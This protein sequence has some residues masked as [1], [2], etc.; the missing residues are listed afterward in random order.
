MTGSQISLLCEFMTLQSHCNVGK[1]ISLIIISMISCQ[2]AVGCFNPL[3]LQS[4]ITYEM[5][6]VSHPF[7]H[8]LQFHTSHRPN[9]SCEI[10]ERRGGVVGAP[11]ITPTDN[12]VVRGTDVC[13]WACECVWERERERESVCVCSRS[14]PVV[15]IVLKRWPIYSIL[16]CL[17]DLPHHQ[18]HWPI[19]WAFGFLRDCTVTFYTGLWAALW[20]WNPKHIFCQSFLS[21]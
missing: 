13:V 18:Y 15:R 12:S 8:L 16:R 1:N 9:Y 11:L 19:S 3:N 7:S 21:L 4:A 6:T 17:P 10:N 20:A 2:W 5:T 14:C